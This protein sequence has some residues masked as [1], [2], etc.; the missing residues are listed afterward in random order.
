MDIDCLLT[1][2]VVLSNNESCVIY[3]IDKVD[4]AKLTNLAGMNI[5]V[6]NGIHF[7]KIPHNPHKLKH[8]S[9]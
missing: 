1:L 7:G 2:S 8:C 6:T 3:D 4:V 5:T 9:E